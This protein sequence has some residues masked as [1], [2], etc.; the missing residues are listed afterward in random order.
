MVH[1]TVLRWNGRGVTGGPD[2]RTLV[3]TLFVAVATTVCAPTD[4]GGELIRLAPFA[5]TPAPLSDNQ[6]VAL[7]GN[8]TVCVIESFEFRVLCTDPKGTPIGVFGAQGEGPGEFLNPVHLFR[9][10]G[11]SVA[12]Y[13]RRLA[14][15][16]VFEPSGTLLSETTLRAPFWIHGTSGTALYGEAGLGMGP[17]GPEVEIQLLDRSSGDI[18]WRRSIYG[19]APTECGTVG[20]GVPRPNGGYVFWA[21]DS[22]LVF[23]DDLNAQTAK[24]VA[25]PTYSAE[26]PNERDVEAYLYDMARLGGAMS[27]PQSAMDPYVMGFREQP[28][29]WFHGFRTFAHDAH[30]RLWVATTRDHDTFSY[31]EVWISTE[32][33]GAVQIRDRLIGYDILGSTLVAL[34]ER[35]PDQNG[36]APRGIDWYDIADV[37]FGRN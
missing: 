16:A 17:S 11:S 9:E 33:T 5:V 35:Q 8:T 6:S 10:S 25:M 31:L 1:G 15:L 34:V 22:D 12:V 27:L 3:V 13:D 19:I 23:L 30:G 4:Q 24:V 28:K 2:A 18:V 32:Y 36:I 20:S 37:D 21:C 29:K 26:L 7:L 14:R